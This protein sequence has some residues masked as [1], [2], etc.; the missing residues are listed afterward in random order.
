MKPA[1]AFSIG[2][3]TG[4]AVVAAVWL[5]YAQQSERA[6]GS[7]ASLKDSKLA[8]ASD[9]IQSLEQ[10]NARLS[11]EVQRLKETAAVLKSNVEENTRFELRRR[12]PFRSQSSEAET[13]PPAPGTSGDWIEQ[14]VAAGDVNALPELEKAARRNNQRALEAIALLAD[15]DQSAALTRVWRSGLLSQPDQGL[16]TRYLAATMEVNPEAEQLLRALAAYPGTDSHLLYAAVDGLANPVFHVSLGHEPPSVAPPHFKPDY[17]ARMRMLDN[18][19]SLST[20]DDLRAYIDQAKA[21]LQARWTE[22]TPS[23][24]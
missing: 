2:L 16:A 24:P 3:W 7:A 4:A 12:I 20:D 13:L 11:A 9:Q 21:E 19:R 10:D 23:S 15:R 18:L 6:H 8:V 5:F 1:A 17:E 14:A 22:T